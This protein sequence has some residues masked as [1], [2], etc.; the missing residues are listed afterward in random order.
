MDLQEKE[1]WKKYVLEAFAELEIPKW[2]FTDDIIADHQSGIDR[3]SREFEE[4]DNEVG[5]S[6]QELAWMRVEVLGAVVGP[7]K[8]P[9]ELWVEVKEWM[10]YLREEDCRKE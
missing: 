5:R 9:V 8:L 10:V 3:V 4:A 6:C 1:N 2:Y 7:E